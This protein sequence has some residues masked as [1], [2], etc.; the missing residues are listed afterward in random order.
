MD[1]H[2]AS[3]EGGWGLT[4][5]HESGFDMPPQASQTMGPIAPTLVK[6]W[7]PAD[8]HIILVHT[9][10]TTIRADFTNI[11]VDQLHFSRY[12]KNNSY[13]Q[14]PHSPFSPLGTFVEVPSNFVKTVSGHLV[15]LAPSGRLTV[16]YATTGDDQP[17]AGESNSY[18]A[19]E[20]FEDRTSGTHYPFICPF[21]GVVGT[22]TEQC[23]FYL[24]RM[25]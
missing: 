19:F 5:R 13:M 21:S 15:D 2:E 20:N 11:G 25:K 23:D 8:L 22:V 9:E 10:D 16:Y 4:R 14:D 3:A 24:W 12:H 1:V 18:H 7:N 17:L 6:S